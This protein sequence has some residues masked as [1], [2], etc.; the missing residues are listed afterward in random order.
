MHTW[1]LLFPCCCKSWSMLFVCLLLTNLQRILHIFLNICSV[2]HVLFYWQWS[3]RCEQMECAW[4]MQFSTLLAVFLV[5]VILGS[6][7]STENASGR[8]SI[9]VAESVDVKHY[10]GWKSELSRHL[11][12]S[13]WQTIYLIVRSKSVY[14]SWMLHGSFCPAIFVLILVLVQQVST[15][16]W[17]KGWSS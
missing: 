10:P 6:V 8:T 4:V 14:K 5:I 7:Q 9:L 12:G 17:F 13:S 1:C 15:H 2:K 11:A 3:V 16:P